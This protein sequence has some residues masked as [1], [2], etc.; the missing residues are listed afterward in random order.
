[1]KEISRLLF[2]VAVLVSFAAASGCSLKRVQPWERDI[3]AKQEMQLDP[4][5]LDS[6]LD[7]HIYYSKEGSSGGRGFGGGGCG[8]N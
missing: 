6:Y 5:P 4:Y 3:L 1:M 7:D 8:C 2:L